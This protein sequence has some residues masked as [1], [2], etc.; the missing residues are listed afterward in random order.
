MDGQIA[1]SG[2]ASHYVMKVMR[3]RVGDDLRLF[4]GQDGE[5]RAQITE[6]GKKLATLIVGTQTR[7]FARVP[8]LWL[9]F[10][11]VKKSR[12]EFIVEKATELGTA[13]LHPVITSRTTA[14]ALRDERMQMI[15]REAAEQTERLDLPQIL[16]PQPLQE[17]LQNR[18]ADRPLIFCDEAGDNQEKP[19]GGTKGR[20][21]PMLEALREIGPGTQKGAVLIGPE[22]GF[23]PEERAMLRA[24]SCVYPVTLGPRILR[25]D[26][27]VLAA[28]SLW[29]SVCGDWQQQQ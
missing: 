16:P 12:T 29:Q 18:E 15:C 3:R 11:P 13:V 20:A 25:S 28:L 22:G 21:R 9:L 10:A 6:A 23:S 17:A 5:W 8:D 24:Q 1:L 19:W 27:A 2:E 14:R 7:A 4:N 26:T